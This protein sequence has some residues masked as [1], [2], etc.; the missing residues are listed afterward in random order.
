MDLI[1]SMSPT[2]EGAAVSSILQSIFA[3]LVILSLCIVVLFIRRW[4]KI[5]FPILTENSEPKRISIV[6][7]TWNEEKVIASKLEDIIS[8]DYPMEF[9]EL[10]V[11]DSASKDSTIE[12]VENWYNGRKSANPRFKLIKEKSREGKSVS[13]NL[14][15][16]SADPSSEIL[17]MSDVDCRLERDV[18]SRI[19]SWFSDPSIGAVTGR[20]ILLN[21]DHSAKSSQEVNYRDFFSR[22]RV[23]ESRLHSTPIF[24]GE[25]AAYRRE[26]LFGHKLVENSNADDSQMAVSSVRSGFRSIYDPETLFYEMAPPDGRSSRIQKIRRAQGLVR[27]FWRNREMVFNSDFGSFRKIMALEFT[28]HI[29]TPIFVL[30][31]FLFGFVHLFSIIGE[32]G[33]D[34]GS[35]VSHSPTIEYLMIYADLLVL[36][37]LFSG[38]FRIPVPGGELSLTFFNYMM[39]LLQA[40]ALI[41]FGK[42]LHQWQQV[43]SVREALAEHDSRVRISEK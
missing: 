19:S 11:I 26:A 1:L 41:L 9:V 10:I 4:S 28:L 18:L 22:I 25:C 6:L 21:P 8:Q 17:M 5:H 32:F 39:V 40:I 35:M 31:G 27:H 20:Q 2:F 29:L 43:P 16:S 37:L 34:H 7:P 3:T 12:I 15:F 14:A 36:F 23:A 24:H 38:T 30:L 42:S 33:F 13:I